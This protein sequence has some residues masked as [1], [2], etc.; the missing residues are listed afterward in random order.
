MP[1]AVYYLPCWIHVGGQHYKAVEVAVG[2]S[3]LG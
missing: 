3:V 2:Y 1:D